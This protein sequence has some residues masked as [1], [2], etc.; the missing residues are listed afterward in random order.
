MVIGFVLL[1]LLAP[2]L[3]AAALLSPAYGG[4]VLLIPLA[5]FVLSVTAFVLSSLYS[6]RSDAGEEEAAA[7]RGFR[8]Y[9]RGRDEGA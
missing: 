1:A 6:T 9:L 8:D 4:W 3:A 2:A 7:W 5:V